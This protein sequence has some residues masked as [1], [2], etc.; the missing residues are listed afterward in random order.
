M[1]SRVDD[2]AVL[3]ICVTEHGVGKGMNGGCVPLHT[4]PQQYCVPASLVSSVLSVPQFLHES[5]LL[6][7]PNFDVLLFFFSFYLLFVVADLNRKSPQQSLH[8]NTFF[9]R[10]FSVL[11]TLFFIF[12]FKLTSFESNSP[13]LSEGRTTA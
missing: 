5:Y 9:L 7:D 2:A 11:F 6:S 10:I 3:I 8:S 12:L 4:L 1:K 13:F